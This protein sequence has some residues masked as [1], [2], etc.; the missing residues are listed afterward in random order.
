MPVL[1]RLLLLLLL[2]RWA[3]LPA[4]LLQVGLLLQGQQQLLHLKALQRTLEELFLLRLPFMAS[5]T[6]K[7]QTRM[8]PK[9][10]PSRFSSRLRTPRAS[11]SV[12][13]VMFV[14]VLRERKVALDAP[15]V[16]LHQPARGP[17]KENAAAYQ[18]PFLPEY[19]LQYA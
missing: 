2:L 7:L 1:T 5:H 15:H 6:A 12:G 9:A 4:R 13:Q 16:V 18:Q 11:V 3:L 17:I 19:A 10:R 14:E 8:A